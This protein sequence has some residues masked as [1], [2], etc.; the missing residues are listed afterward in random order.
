MNN[1]R[2]YMGYE[3]NENLEVVG[4][5]KFVAFGVMAE[6]TTCYHKIINGVEDETFWYSR[7]RIENKTVFFLE[8]C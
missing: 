3:I 2:K 5:A 7:G 6:G 1:K 8:G 4:K